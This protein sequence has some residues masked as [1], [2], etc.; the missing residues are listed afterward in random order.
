MNLQR[1]S[2][3]GAAGLLLALVSCAR[4]GTLKYISEQTSP[5]S[6]DST[7][8]QAPAT[9]MNPL[10][11]VPL[12]GDTSRGFVPGTGDSTRR[13]LGSLRQGFT[14]DTLNIIL[15]GDN[16]PAFRSTRLKP[17]LVKVQ[18]MISWNPI[19]FLDGLIHIPV[20]LVKG[21]I[22]D[23]ALIRDIPDLVK[24]NPS[25]GREES[26]VKAVMAKIDSIEAN[27]QTVAA[28]INTGDLVKDGRYPHMWERFLKITQPL[29]TRVPYFPIAGNHER[30]DT[31]QGLENWRTATGLPIS[32]DRLYYSFDSADGWVRFLALDSN[33]MT[34]PHN[35]WTREVE[36]QY[37][38]EQI[39][40]LVKS[41]KG[42]TGP[43]FV[44][45][46][47]PPFSS[48]FHRVE[49][50][51]DDVL[52]ER[53]ERMVKAMRE[54]GIGVIATGHEHAYERALLT[55]P[56]AVI[57]SIVAGGAGSPLHQ[58]PPPAQSA[59]LFS[60]YKVA[61]SEIKPENVFTAE[62]YHFVHVRLWF[63][64]GEILTYSVDEGANTKLIDTVE[65]DLKRYGTPKIDQYKRIIPSEG[66]EQPPPT[67]ESK[68]KKDVIASSDSTKASERLENEPAPGEQKVPPPAKKPTPSKKSGS[69]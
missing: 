64:G 1:L 50:Q 38:D 54:A 60:E 22:P 14:A 19:N 30:T 45:M 43:C 13:F 62:V 11:W 69:K 55:W 34:D 35:Y 23:A 15:M 33:P 4:T 28:V 21:L 67:E 8:A 7:Q 63:G 24:K 27:H 2:S 10:P 51:N 29:Y 41:L 25:W 68:D 16:R 20:A 46:H 9:P 26:V 66:P 56:D 59:A 36:V 3:F 61:G 53:R 52:R 6:T 57:I 5:V 49:W 44:F 48:G 31:E 58:I 12:F 40:W 42:H 37:S 47:H 65:I 17:D 39:D 32:G 18:G